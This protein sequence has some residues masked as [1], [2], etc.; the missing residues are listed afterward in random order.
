MY[1]YMYVHVLGWA[2][3]KI[4]GHLATN[5]SPWTLTPP[6]KL[7]HGPLR[8]LE[9]SYNVHVHVYTRVQC[10]DVLKSIDVHL[11]LRNFTVQ[12]LCEVFKNIRQ[13][14]SM[15][16]LVQ[17]HL[18]CIAV[19]KKSILIETSTCNFVFACEWWKGMDMRLAD[20]NYRLYNRYVYVYVLQFWSWC[21]K[22]QLQFNL[23]FQTVYM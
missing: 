5:F 21:L 1:M 10:P 11:S 18:C 15:L 8:H 7:W 3:T 19:Y 14:D 6:Q 9:Y 20:T 4:Y 16:Q 23:A 22:P 13:L 17:I 12:Q 2:A